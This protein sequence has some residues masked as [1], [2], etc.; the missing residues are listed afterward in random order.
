[1]AATPEKAGADKVKG[2]PGRPSKFTEAIAAE[3][4]KRMSEGETLRAICR[5][6]HMP[7]WQT[8]Y[9]WMSDD[10]HVEFSRR[11]ARARVLGYD[12]IA[13]ETLE[14][15]DERPEYATSEGGSRV[16]TGY[17]AW[18]KNRAEQRMKLLACWDSRR[19]GVK[20]STELTGAGG[21][22]I[23]VAATLQAAPDL[24][25]VRQKIRDRKAAK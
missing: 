14:I 2:R 16:D 23:A 12:A 4:C 24:E 19:Y 9:D 11:V 1:M 21:G 22:P 10:R 20:T 15:L 17:V 5:D 3:I 6:E 25:L 8:V 13:E 7:A 18:Q